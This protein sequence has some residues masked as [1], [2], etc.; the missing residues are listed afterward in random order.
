MTLEYIK[1]DRRYFWGH[2]AT[3][4]REEFG[5]HE[6]NILIDRSSNNVAV[7]LSTR[8]NPDGADVSALIAIAHEI[9]EGQDRDRAEVM[10]EHK[11]IRQLLHS[12]LTVESIRKERLRNWKD[13][14][15]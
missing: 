15:A 3:E 4:K 9:M 8:G 14:P 2:K 11:V 13:T 5:A 7:R 10:V 6:K 12:A 1:E